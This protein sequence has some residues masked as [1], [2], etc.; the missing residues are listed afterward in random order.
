MMRSMYS[1]VSGLKIHQTKMDVIGNNIANVNTIGFKSQKVSFSD[2]F[3]QTS[4]I[5][6]GASEDGLKGGSNAKQVGLGAS[7]AQISTN[8]EDRGGAQSTGNALDVMIN[9]NSFFIIQGDDGSNYYTK[10]GNF[11]TDTAGNLVTG[12]GNY[13]MGYTAGRDEETGDYSLQMDKLRPIS[14]YGSEYMQTPPAQTTEAVLTGNIN[15]QD[16]A[17][18]TGGSGVRSTK[19]YVFDS[20]GNK[21]GVQ[22]DIEKVSDIEFT[23]K[24]SSIFS[25]TEEAEGISAIFSGDGVN[26]DGSITL[27]FDGTKGTITNEPSE[28][29]LNLTDGTNNLEAFSED[30]TV[31][32]SSMTAYGS[33][34]SIAANPGSAANLGAGKAVGTMTTYGISENG[35]VVASYTNGDV[36]IIGQLAT[37]HFSN[38]A[39]LEKVGNNMFGE[40]LNSGDL[41]IQTIDA[42][43]ETMTGGAVEMSNVDLASEFTDM[44]V[45][46]RGFQANSRI[47]TTSD[48]MIEE[49][50]SLKR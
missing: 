20:L 11:T 39:G 24:P 7:V 12:G 50:L 9:G 37:A 13:V 5:A 27:T 17:Y 48:S 26:A 43:G 46:Q 19:L 6:S 45:T 8:I 25:G 33:S 21:Y 3:Y 23:L 2:L 18:A 40:T 1:G 22:F 14:I 38:A 10:A 31:D 34:T 35:S 15:A 47:I 30:I 44:I 16:D 29:T 32:F 42:A 4:Q 41:T 36:V 49:L 28:F